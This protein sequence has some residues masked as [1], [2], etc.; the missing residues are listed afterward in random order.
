MPEQPLIDVNEAI[1]IPSPDVIGSLGEHNMV[2]ETTFSDMMTS[3]SNPN[4]FNTKMRQHATQPIVVSQLK[5]IP[6]VGVKTILFKGVIKGSTGK[7]YDTH[8]LFKRVNFV[9]DVDDVED[10]DKDVV[11]FVAADG[12][13]YY[14]ERIN[15]AKHDL[16]CSCNCLDFKWTFARHNAKT[17]DLYGGAP[18]PY[19]PKTD[20]PSR[21]LS[22]KPAMCKH[23]IKTVDALVQADMA[24]E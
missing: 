15:L 23:L 10:I 17:K 5:I 11:E 6:Y 2:I 14:I 12:E 7:T 18:A 13:T 9:G 4:N 1:F 8:V 21:N 22:D 3:L 24:K 19:K 20:R 16:S